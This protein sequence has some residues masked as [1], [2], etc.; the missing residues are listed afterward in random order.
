VGRQRGTGS[1]GI[2]FVEIPDF[3][4]TAMA[5]SSVQLYDSDAKRKEGLTRAGVLGAGSPVT[6]V[7][8]VGAVLKYDCTVYGSLIDRQAGK[9]KIDVAVRLL[10]GAEQIFVGQ[11]I[12][13]AIP[14]GNST[15]A[16][17]AIGEIKL[18]ATLPPGDYALELSAYDRL[19]KRPPQEVAQWVDVALIQ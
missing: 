12:A 6:R 3:N 9:Q 7:F 19:E 13:L 16:V 10:R 11:P 18:P 17:H 4:R 2:H 15:E 1:A 14:D 8:A 5:L